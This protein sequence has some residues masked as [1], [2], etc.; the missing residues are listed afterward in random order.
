MD[1]NKE[2][3]GGVSARMQ[4]LERVFDAATGVIDG[5]ESA[6]GAFSADVEITPLHRSLPPAPIRIVT[7]TKTLGYPPTSPSHFTKNE[8]KDPT[9][10]KLSRTELLRDKH[11]FLK[12]RN[13]SFSSCSSPSGLYSEVSI[14]LWTEGKPVYNHSSSSERS[15]LVIILFYDSPADLWSL[16]AKQVKRYTHSTVDNEEIIVPTRSLS[17]L[18]LKK[19][20]KKILLFM[21]IA[22]RDAYRMFRRLMDD[23]LFIADGK[24]QF[25]L[26]ESETHVNA[27]K[28]IDKFCSSSFQFDHH[29]YMNNHHE[30]H[31]FYANRTG[32]TPGTK[33]KSSDVPVV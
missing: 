21:N 12:L 29:G 20:L 3:T 17:T 32:T 28:N 31:N 23:E 8:P 13:L 30:R 25:M 26:V 7:E 27:M 19:E 11:Q 1:P 33:Y 14:V 18:E 24:E 6:I 10:A 5:M 2:L 16:S 9:V 4:T 22:P 15:R